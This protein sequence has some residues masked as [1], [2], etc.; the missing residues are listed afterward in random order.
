MTTPTLQQLRTATHID[1]EPE[2]QPQIIDAQKFIQGTYRPS[3]DQYSA[4]QNAHELV[5]AQIANLRVKV[6]LDYIAISEGNGLID[7]GSK[8]TSVI[9]RVTNRYLPFHREDIVII[10][11][12][13][14]LSQPSLHHPER[15]VE[16]RQYEV[17]EVHD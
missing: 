12:L 10:G 11:T 4:L 17:E 16:V 8:K 3:M 6:G 9:S 13:E 15:H 1:R 2:S 5:N 7:R 14:E